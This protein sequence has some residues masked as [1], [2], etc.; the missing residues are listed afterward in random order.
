MEKRLFSATGE[1]ATTSPDRNSSLDGL[2]LDASGVDWGEETAKAPP[3]AGVQNLQTRLRAVALRCAEMTLSHLTRYDYL[4][5][6]T[7]ESVLSSYDMYVRDL[8][9]RSGIMDMLP[10][11]VSIRFERWDEKAM[12]ELRNLTQVMG[13]AV[14]SRVIHCNFLQLVE[15]PTQLYQ[16]FPAVHEICSTLMCPVVQFHERDFVTVTSVNPVTAFS[17]IQLIDAEMTTEGGFRPFTS[18]MTTEGTAWNF[19]CERQFGSS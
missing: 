19:L 16:N 6:Q 11:I 5:R 2:V 3:A 4:D 7:Q 14:F 15:Q 12:K 18:V 13:E 9:P 17:A 1:A 10:F 8:P